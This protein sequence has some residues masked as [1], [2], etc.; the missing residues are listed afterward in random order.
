MAKFTGYQTPWGTAQ[1]KNKLCN[2]VT[3]YSTSSHG[4]I[5]VTKEQN[6]KIPPVFRNKSGWYEEDCEALIP[7][8]FIV[9]D[10]REVITQGLQRW[11]PVAYEYHFIGEK[12]P[13]KEILEKIRDNAIFSRMKKGSVIEFKESIK[14]S[15]G[16]EFKEL[17][18][19]GGSKFTHENYNF[20][21]FHIS[22]WKT[23]HILSDYKY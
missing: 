17:K 4:G 11:F 3:F 15:D 2:G 5:K 22:N 12:E 19:L 8:Y 9:G 6:K 1:N 23:N 21:L 14:F 16:S 10:K 13:T 7:S 18:W 20:P